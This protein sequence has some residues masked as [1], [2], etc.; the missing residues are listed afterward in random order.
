MKWTTAQVVFREFPDEV[1]LAI[2]LSRCPNRCRGCHS[3]QLREDIGEYLDMITIDNLIEDHPQ[4]TC[5]GFM[6]GDAN[7]EEIAFFAKMIKEDYPHLKVGWY[8]GRYLLPDDMIVDNLDYVKTGP[9]IPEKG[10]LSNPNTNQRMW[11]RNGRSW[12]DIT[13][14]FWP[15][16]MNFGIKENKQP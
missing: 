12:D 11:K 10:P 4:I 14:R 9:Y 5:I 16:T 1:T 2:N 8:S 13:Y 15:S 7:P 3:P 6:G